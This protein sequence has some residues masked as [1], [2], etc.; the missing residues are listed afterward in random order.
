MK[1]LNPIGLN[2]LILAML[3]PLVA[4]VLQSIFWAAIKPFAWFLFFPAVF[5]SSW[6]GGLPGGAIATLIS[7][8]LAWWAFIPP[9]YSFAL[10]DPFQLGSIGLFMGMGFLFGYSH[11]RIKKANRETAEALAAVSSAKDQLE[12]R[13]RE[14]TAELAQINESLRTSEARMAGIVDTAI[15]A[16]ISVDSEQKI[17]LFNAGAEEIF[18]CPAGKAMGQPIDMFIPQR[19]REQ[20]RQHVQGFGQTGVTSRSMRS[21][22]PLSGLRADGEEFPI[23]ASISQ[24]EVAGQ[25]LFTVILRD[26]TE[27]KQAEEK[28]KRAMEEL[29]RS[30]QELEQFAYVA[31]HDLQEPLRMVSSFTQLLAR[32]YKDRLDADADD[33][34][35]YAVNG[36]NRMQRL[37]SDLLMYSRLGTRG[38]PFEPC[39]VQSILGEVLVNLQPAIAESRAVITN[40]ALPTVMADSSQLVQLFQNLISNAVR[41][42][43][44]EAPRI[45]VAAEE[46]PAEWLFSVR[47]NGIGIAPEY[48]E[49]IFV[50]FQRLQPQ[51]HQ[52]GTGIGLAICKRIAERH[53]GKLWVESEPGKG[54]TFYF[55]ISKRKGEQGL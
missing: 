13:V 22:G 3:L 41:F 50:I 44:D 42:H 39:D 40:D 45:H 1:A 11:E 53:G 38:R 26:I 31:S 2:R 6:I 7:T 17:V 23:E 25:K 37:I 32:R 46:K 29:E 55:T 51:S 43:G 36:A 9:E 35:G 52:A 12:T 47:D 49:R 19:F 30:N 28:L 24:I 16:I 54:S 21:R 18:R 15:D 4:F 20:H 8:T 27:R 48:R 34:I 5:F 33:F 10:E 14:R